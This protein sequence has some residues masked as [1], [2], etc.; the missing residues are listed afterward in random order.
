MK[1]VQR[2]LRRSGYLYKKSK[3]EIVLSDHHKAKRIKI[4]GNWVSQKHDLSRTIL[5]DEKRFILD[6]P[7]D[8]RT[9]VSKKEK[10]TRKR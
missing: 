4:V 2:H 1:T 3:L 10:I 9:W 6:G 5:S 7:D 8:R